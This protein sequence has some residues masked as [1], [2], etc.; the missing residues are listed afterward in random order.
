ME[1]IMELEPLLESAI[2]KRSEV[3]NLRPLKEL[4]SINVASSYECAQPTLAL[5]QYLSPPLQKE[6][7]SRMAA[8]NENRLTPAKAAWVFELASRL[9]NTT[10]KEF[11]FGIFGGQF[12]HCADYERAQKVWHMLAEKCPNLEQINDKRYHETDSSNP[13]KKNL[14]IKNVMP[15]LQKFGKL[16]HIVL[17]YYICDSED[18][19]Q[20]AH[21]FPKLLTLSVTFELVCFDTLKKLFLLQ[22]LERLEIN[23]DKD[24]FFNIDDAAVLGEQTHYF[25]HFKTECIE[26]LPCLQYCSGGGEYHN[27]R[28]YRGKRKLALKEMEVLGGFDLQLVPFLEDLHLKGPLKTHLNGIGGLSD[29]TVL[30]LSDVKESDVSD[31]LT[32]CGAKLHELKIY[33]WDSEAGINPYELIVKCP[34]LHKLDVSSDLYD[35]EENIFKP[36]VNANHLKYLKDFSLSRIGNK[37]PPDLTALVLAAPDLE[38]F[39][40]WNFSH[41]HLVHLTEQ[42]VDGRIL[43]N[44]KSFTFNCINQ[45]P[46]FCTELI[47]FLC[48]LPVYAPRLALMTCE[49]ASTEFDKQVKKSYLCNGFD[50]IDGFKFILGHLGIF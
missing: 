41:E 37:F 24:E 13:K 8:S 11:D 49:I 32:Q 38:K 7:S 46:S 17:K 20:L 43:Q 14:H 18:L 2:V 30:S 4:T 19:V 28:P 29:L 50:Q 31:L 47:K 16:K 21:H 45:E 35:G 1:A 15:F 22:D 25:N 3:K 44:L 23:W 9:L 42:L 34:Q 40:N 48:F 27:F 39:S 5:I 6:I 36:Q 12:Q 10:T 26:Q 33:I